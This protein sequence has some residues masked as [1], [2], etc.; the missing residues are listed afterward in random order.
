MQT[1]RHALA[2]LRNFS[3]EVQKFVGIK[4][5]RKREFSLVV[6]SQPAEDRTRNRVHVLQHPIE[7]GR[8]GKGVIFGRVYVAKVA[9]KIERC[10]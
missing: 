7:E 1:R 3:P 8:L 4:L 10:S 2:A 6:L 9:E 5:V